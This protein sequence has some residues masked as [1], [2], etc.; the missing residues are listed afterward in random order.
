[1]V[2]QKKLVYLDF[3]YCNTEEENVTPVCVSWQVV[4]GGKRHAVMSQWLYDGGPSLRQFKA[5]VDVWARSGYVFSS[6]SWEAES[7][8]LLAL[9]FDSVP[10]KAV[11]LYLE[12]RQLLNHNHELEY[13]KQLIKGKVR[14][15]DVP[16][17]WREEK[18]S[19]EDYSQ[20]E[21][22]YAA[23]AFKMLG[24]IVDTQEKHEVRGRI[25]RG[26][27]FNEDEKK[28]IME[29]CASDVEHLAPLH[30][31]M[32]SYWVDYL[33]SHEDEVDE[34][35]LVREQYRRAEYA[36]RTARMVGVGYPVDVPAL[37][38]LTANIP[39]LLQALQR[40]I[41]KRTE[42]ELGFKMF[43]WDRKTKSFTRNVKL[44]GDWVDQ[45]YGKRWPK[46][47]PTKAPC[48]D[49]ETL[50]KVSG[51]RHEFR[52]DPVD[53]LLR[54]SRFNQ[55][56]NG[57]RP[58]KET[59]KKSFYDYLGKDG[60]ARP[61]FGI[62]GAQS[63]RSQPSATGYVFLKSAALRGLVHPPVGKMIVGSDY[64][65][66]EFLLSALLSGDKKMLEAYMSGDVYMAFAIQSRAAPKGAT[67]HTHKDIRERYKATVLAIS[68][69]MTARGLSQKIV[70]DT[71]QAC[72]E[73]EAQVLID[74]FYETYCDF[75]EWKE[76]VQREYRQSGTIRLPC[77]W[78]M[79]ADNQNFR[80]V[81]NM[82][83]QGVGGSI[84][85]K[86]IALAQDEGL[87]PIMTLH[88]AIYV[89]E[90][91]NDWVSV[92]LLARVMNEAFHFYMDPYM[93]NMG[94]MVDIR[95]DVYCWGTGL[96]QD[97]KVITPGGNHVATQEIY[98]DE[99]AV[100]EYEMLRPYLR[101]EE[102]VL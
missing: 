1:M 61:Y 86:S 78:R 88:D 16:P 21:M 2:P 50:S 5:F 71:K 39:S 38:A 30:S 70:N 13:G 59:S 42:R 68:Y 43:S 95:Q 72:T 31:E 69:D 75:A 10:W 74:L 23:A 93:R 91:L 52:D 97:G 62:Y 57:F 28:R 9:G 45:K 47:T 73:E 90:E 7:R 76:T 12:Y 19:S 64:G 35:E 4:D 102:F 15:T 77:G 82:P 79:L 101:E 87:T 55:S 6:Y 44:I 58:L 36:A 49:E 20:A 37:R 24:K 63:S 98:I 54:F 60:R 66:E 22:N 48:L 33:S 92:D 25:I 99:R 27:P 89:E 100:K 80:S 11:D 85:R 8:A 34:Q 40:D 29:Y 81:G 46:R 94:V 51:S 17:R 53:Q 84:M 67:K 96:V 83:V 32:W 41:I 14:V 65:S 26:G 56:I 3:E 18:D